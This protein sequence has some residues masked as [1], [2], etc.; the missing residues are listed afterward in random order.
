MGVSEVALMSKE[1]LS[2]SNVVVAG[3]NVGIVLLTGGKGWSTIHLPLKL[4]F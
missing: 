2:T 4:K 3:T 1:L